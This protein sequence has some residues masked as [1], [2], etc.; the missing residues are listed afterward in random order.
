MLLMANILAS[1]QE[2]W[3]LLEW[4][5]ERIHPRVSSLAVDLWD[6]DL[7]P[8]GVMERYRETI[9]KFDQ[10]LFFK[11][12]KRLE[13]EAHTRSSLTYF[14]HWTSVLSVDYAGELPQHI[15]QLDARYEDS[16]DLDVA[17]DVLKRP[18]VLA[19]TCYQQTKGASDE[20]IRRFAQIEGK[21]AG[22]PSEILSR[23]EHGYL[24]RGPWLSTRFFVFDTKILERFLRSVEAWRANPDERMEYHLCRM[25]GA[26]EYIFVHDP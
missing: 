23:N 13:L 11:L 25:L 21:L 24:V 22:L 26:D 3:A 12:G 19:A 7:S 14:R 15:V 1:R 16:I 18:E 9:D 10:V 5:H 8:S 20:A 2:E 17:R 6:S 4:N